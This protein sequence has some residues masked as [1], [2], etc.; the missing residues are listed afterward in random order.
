MLKL[1]I[2]ICAFAYALN[3]NVAAVAAVGSFQPIDNAE[4]AYFVY[5]RVDVPCAN[6]VN[7]A[8]SILM[9]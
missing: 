7:L 9:A 5:V 2:C 8:L 6:T 4:S 3:P 1:L